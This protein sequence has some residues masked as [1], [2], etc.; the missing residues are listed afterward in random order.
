MGI[1]KFT[2]LKEQKLYSAYGLSVYGKVSTYEWVVMNKPKEPCYITLRIV[3]NANKQVLLDMYLGNN[4]ILDT[5]FR[6]NIDD[7]L[8]W[9]AEE[10]HMSA[11][12]E[13]KAYK[14]LL[15][16][17]SLFKSRIA[18]RKFKQR[19][20]R[21]LDR[22]RKEIEKANKE[23]L[24]RIVDR[25]NKLGLEYI[26]SGVDE[27]IVYSLLSEQAKRIF[28]DIKEFSLLG[29]EE[30]NRARERVLKYINSAKENPEMVEL[31]ILAEGTYSE[32]LRVLENMTKKKLKE[33]LN[34]VV[35]K[36]K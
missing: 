11:E 20:Q 14:Y 35:K 16:S 27:V 8:W 36:Y 18:E 24:A 10:H 25:C 19:Q 22:Q 34:K 5:T 13:E 26:R 31:R 28:K 29:R 2:G 9:V 33:E 6:N 21:E 7:F 1:L 17:Y 12:I 23:K 15:Q 30:A 4:A 32:V 3:D